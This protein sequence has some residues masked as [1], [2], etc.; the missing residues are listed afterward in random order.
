[1][2]RAGFALAVHGGA[3]GSRAG[4]P[5]WAEVA[6]AALAG[7]LAAGSAVLAAGGPALDAVVAAVAVLEDCPLFNAG[8][9][10]VLNADGEV[11]MDAAVMEGGSRRA[12]AVAGLRGIAN[13]VR[14][15]DAVL[16]D[17]RHV[18]LAGAGAERF[19]LASGAATVDPDALVTEARRAQWQRARA[20]TPG[21]RAGG[22][23]GA[24]ARDAH[25]HLAAATSTGGL[26][27]KL[28][29]RV[30]DSAQI[31]AGTWADDATCAISATGDG[32]VFIRAA[33][34]SRVDSLVR[35]A[36]TSLADA[37]ARALS[38]V[39]HLGGNGG[40]IAIATEGP[41]VTPYLTASMPR[42]VLEEGKEMEVA[43]G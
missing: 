29:G 21:G 14:A 19:A 22:T 27:G 18:L 33:F 12:G 25:G 34:A 35:L 39:T 26:S 16:R 30:S 38:E 4:D 8:R 3:G 40:C 13:P 5:A 31:G 2:K 11:E 23:V 15:A 28:A 10:S 43:P 9:G 20:G 7:S 6:R 1:M 36:R 24:V 37:C 17:G 32:D 42:G 41:P